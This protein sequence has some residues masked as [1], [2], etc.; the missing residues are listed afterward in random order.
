[1]SCSVGDRVRMSKQGRRQK[2]NMRAINANRITKEGQNI[3]VHTLLYLYPGT[4]EEFT[5][6]RGARA[7]AGPPLAPPL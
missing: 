5:D 6:L 1:M 7:P 3:K 2:Y 4:K